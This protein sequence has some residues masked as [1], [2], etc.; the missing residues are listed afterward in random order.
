MLLTLSPTITLER[1]V[2]QM[3]VTAY[4][5]YSQLSFESMWSHLYAQPEYTPFRGDIIM[6]VIDAVVV[7]DVRFKVLIPVVI[8]SSVFWDTTLCPVK[9]NR[10]FGGTYHLDFQGR[11]ISQAINQ[12]ESSAS[13]VLHASCWSPTWLTLRP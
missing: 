8:K 1:N 5:T 11:E 9:V 12:H 7:G 13:G 3:S 6:A 2:C 10:H 4:A